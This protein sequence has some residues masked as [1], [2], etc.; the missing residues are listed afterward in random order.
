MKYS[1]ITMLFIIA[2]WI[3][4]SQ[5]KIHSIKLDEITEV[6][7]YLQNADLVI[8]KIIFDEKAEVKQIVDF[9]R[10]TEFTY[11]T[12]SDLKTIDGES[13]WKVKLSFKGQRDQ[14]YFFE[15]HAF[16]GKST[17]LIPDGSTDELV[18]IIQK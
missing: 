15:D 11:A 5:D 1:I 3:S 18:L 6:T 10:K 16:I 12:M 8:K 17:F 7:A 4:F 14:M 2:G 13:D 9:L